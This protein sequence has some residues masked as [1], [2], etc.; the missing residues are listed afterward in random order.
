MSK[1]LTGSIIAAVAIL[2]VVL[3][4]VMING[5][6][7]TQQTLEAN[8][9]WEVS[10]MQAGESATENKMEPVFYVHFENGK[11][12]MG[13][14][15]VKN[16]D[17]D[18]TEAGLHVKYLKNDVVTISEVRDGK[19]SDKEGRVIVKEKGYDTFV[20]MPENKDDVD[21]IQL[22]VSDL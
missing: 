10:V 18:H 21:E 5:K 3:A 2:I 8:K 15:N 20:V 16:V 1:K 11:A 13:D 9:L 12:W 22:K 7:S 19:P 4:V 14:I 17:Y 6:T